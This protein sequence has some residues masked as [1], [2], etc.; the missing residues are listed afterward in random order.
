MKTNNRTF[1]ERQKEYLQ[2]KRAN[3][4]SKI[5]PLALI[6]MASVFYFGSLCYG[7]GAEINDQIAAIHEVE[8]R[9]QGISTNTALGLY[10]LVKD[11]VK[12][13]SKRINQPSI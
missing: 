11:P 9:E 1:R 6:G 3:L 2:T 4:R 10:S 5:L 8:S 7:K 12:E 13:E